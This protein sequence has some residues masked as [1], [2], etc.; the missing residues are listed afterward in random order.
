MPAITGSGRAKLVN[1]RPVA[2]RKFDEPW[3]RN[4]YAFQWDVDLTG[5]LTVGRNAIQL[6]GFNPHHFAGMFR[7]P[8]LYR[9]R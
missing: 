4:G 8:F 1:G 6:I 7:R 5:K 2:Q 3:W 9:P